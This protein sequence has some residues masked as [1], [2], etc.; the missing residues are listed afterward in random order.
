MLATMI[1]IPTT[2]PNIIFAGDTLRWSKSLADYPADAFALHYKLQPLTG[3]TAITLAATANGTDYSI[4]VSAA[5]SAGY[6]SGDYRWTSYVLDIATGLER[7]VIDS[8]ALT[9]KPDPLTS[10]ADLR[11][12]ARKTLDAIEAVLE[13]EASVAQLKYTVDNKS[14]ERRTFPELLQLRSFY[15]DEVRREEQAEAIRKGLSSG[16]RILTRFC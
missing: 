3:G 8:G 9:I 16:G 7:T 10:T 13:G 15:L 1:T 2:E 12:H 14:L 5:Q 11:S 4:A 6:A